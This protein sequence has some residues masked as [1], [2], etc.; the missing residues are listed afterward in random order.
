MAYFQENKHYETYLYFIETEMQ[1]YS[2][3]CTERYY[4]FVSSKS[5][6]LAYIF[7]MKRKIKFRLVRQL[8]RPVQ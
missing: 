6:R 3:K 4:I 7:E 1:G 2:L 8:V 5:R